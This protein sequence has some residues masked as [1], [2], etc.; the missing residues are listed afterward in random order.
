MITAILL[1]LLT[2]A[3]VAVPQS[4]SPAPSAAATAAPQVQ[5]WLNGGDEFVRGDKVRVYVKADADGYMLVLHAEPNGRIHVLF[6]LDP[7]DDNYVQA[8]KTYEVRGRGDRDAFTVYGSRGAGAVYAAFSQDP[9]QLGGFALN[10]HWDYRA[11]A[12]TAGDDAEAD[13]TSLAQQ[14]AGTGQFTYDLAHYDVVDQVARGS[15]SYGGSYYYP[16]DGYYGGWYSPWRSGLSFGISFG[17]PWYACWACGGLYDPWFYNAWY[18]P[19]Y[20]DPWFY[21]PYYYGYYGYYRPYYVN[22]YAYNGWGYGRGAWWSGYRG[23]SAYG[24]QRYAFY[25]VQPGR[26]TLSLYGGGRSVLVSGRRPDVG[27]VVGGRAA[28]GAGTVSGRR[29]VMPPATDGGRVVTGPRRAADQGRVQ[30]RDV[31]PRPV[32]ATPRRESVAPRDAVI[33]R[34]P[35]PRAVGGTNAPSPRG[36]VPLREGEARAAPRR[37]VSGSRDMRGLSPVE[38]NGRAMPSRDG[39]GPRTVR[40]LSP[41]EGSRAERPSYARPQLERRQGPPPEGRSYE[42]PSRPERGASPSYAPRGP[43]RSAPPAMSRPSAPRVSAPSRSSGPSRSSAPA[44]S[45]GRVSSGGRRRG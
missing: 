22:R 5:V 14:M 7:G 38:G 19:F 35:A 1:P 20:Y 30:P 17:S 10:G 25:Y 4:E 11:Q 6:P 2:A 31:Q 43:V 33:R 37:D 12:F 18:D 15:S 42:A 40:G 23:T 39:S 3:A 8:G 28:V 36:L 32:Q 44:R 24:R 21:R 27:G 13:L 9:F 29:A 34:V 16:Y 45:G 26:R 41:V